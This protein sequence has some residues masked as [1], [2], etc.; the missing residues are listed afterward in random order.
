MGGQRAFRF[1]DRR[2][3]KLLALLE[4]PEKRLRDARI[5]SLLAGARKKI[6]SGERK[7]LNVYEKA[8]LRTLLEL[9][10]Q[11]TPFGD[12]RLRPGERDS[13]RDIYL[14]HLT[15]LDSEEGKK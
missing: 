4:H 3:G 12:T 15:Q 2:P 7:A 9:R 8:A 1:E 13:A 10:H 5:L 6:A 14:K 11:E